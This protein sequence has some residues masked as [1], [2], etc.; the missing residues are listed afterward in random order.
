M[1]SSAVQLAGQQAAVEAAA[2]G[3]AGFSDTVKT[4]SLGA[5]KPSTTA[6]ASTLGGTPST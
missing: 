1:A 6:G 5:P 2:A 4:G 3:G